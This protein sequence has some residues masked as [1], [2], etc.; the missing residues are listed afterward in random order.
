M[1]LWKIKRPILITCPKAIT[2]CLKDEV[3]AL[4]LPLRSESAA[5][6]ETEGTLT[7]TIA[8][9][10]S[11]RT[12][13]HVLF[14]LKEFQARDGDELYGALRRLPWE[15]YLPRKGYFSVTSSVD[16]PT[17]RDSRFANLRCKDAV[18]DRIRQKTGARPD[19]GPSRAQTVLHLFWKADLCR[20][21]LDTSGEPLS[22][23][24][25]RKIPWKAP[26]Q[27]TL[28]AAVVLA[29]GW[30]GQ[31]AFVNPMCGSGTLAVEAALIALERAPGLLRNN[32]GFMHLAGFDPAAYQEIRRVARRASHRS[33]PGRVI[34]SDRDPD[35]VAAARKNAATAGLEE[36]IEFV[37]CDFGDTPVP[38][39]GGVVVLNPEYGQR[40]GDL[41]RL[42]AVYAGLG[43]FFK[44]SCQGYR[45]YIFTGNLDLAKRI[46]LRT[47][48][49]IPFF[50][51]SIEC[52][53][54]EYELYPGSRK[55]PEDLPPGA[56]PESPQRHSKP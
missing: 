17:I 24:G 22:R 10:L 16:N 4:G 32:F 33:L 51:G 18:A 9:N 37:V 20:I 55:S 44:R 21:Y 19:S 46:G 42:E 41:K 35:A 39:G 43:D 6:V 36:L 49:R 2:P 11:L 23:R 7:D 12:G 31:G 38:E 8:L 40:L 48:R 47:R 56:L 28:A 52:R 5:F 3:A 13:Q 29:T 1:P 15:D 27:E 26:M 34:A 45:G 54:L 25:Y 53:L 50:N 30:D 14:L